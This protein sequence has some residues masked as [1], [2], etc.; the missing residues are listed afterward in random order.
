V[1]PLLFPKATVTVLNR[2]RDRIRDVPDFPRKGILFR[3]LTP[4]LEDPPLFKALID[5]LVAP[6]KGAGLTRVAAIESRGFLFGAPMAM[7]LGAGMSLIRK[8]GKLPHKTL[9]RSYSLEYGE[10]VLEMHANTM[11]PADKVLIV[12]DL[13]ATGGTAAAAAHLCRDAGAEVVGS[14]FVVELAFLDGRKK[15]EG[16]VEALLRY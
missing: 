11:S 2:L 8:A 16:R 6:W 7:A 5:E 13:L 4:V 9:Q 14:A 15:L 12:D 3:D 10:G 1:R